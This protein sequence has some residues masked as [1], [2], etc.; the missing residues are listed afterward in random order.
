[1]CHIFQRG[2]KFLVRVECL[3]ELQLR[4]RNLYLFLVASLG[5]RSVGSFGF[6]SARSDGGCNL[7]LPQE[8]VFLER[9]SR[10]LGLQTVSTNQT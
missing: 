9:Q 1:M 4:E 2:A 6:H 5:H 8:L 7:S 10:E 3:P